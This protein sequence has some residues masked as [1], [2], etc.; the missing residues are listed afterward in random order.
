MVTILWESAYHNVSAKVCDNSITERIFPFVQHSQNTRRGVD[1]WPPTPRRPQQHAPDTWWRELPIVH[2]RVINSNSKINDSVCITCCLLSFTS[3]CSAHTYLNGN[4]TVVFLR[5]T[6]CMSHCGEDLWFLC[7][8]KWSRAMH[9]Q[10]C[11]GNKF[12]VP[13][14]T[15]YTC[16]R[17]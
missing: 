5:H 12:V 1:I 17:R 4:W 10:T 15:L 14:S 13:Y 7:K 6:L 8:A 3:R 16:T 2:C 11:T 9:H